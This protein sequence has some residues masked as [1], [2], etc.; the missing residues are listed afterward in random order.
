MSFCFCFFFLR[1]K[2]RVSFAFVRLVVL[3]AIDCK[4]VGFF[5]SKSFQPSFR[6]PQARSAGASH[7]RKTCEAREKKR[8]SPVSLSVFA[9][10]PDLLF[11][12][13]Q[14]FEYTKR[15]TVLKSMP[16]TYLAGAFNLKQQSLLD[17]TYQRAFILMINKYLL[18][19]RSKMSCTRTYL[20]STL[21]QT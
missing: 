6:V 14:V 17:L 13:S 16:A 4:T 3:P 18:C 5:S 1:D 12:C 7:T 20:T 2:R 11:D 19:D 21:R 10:A 15:R 8:L 9:L